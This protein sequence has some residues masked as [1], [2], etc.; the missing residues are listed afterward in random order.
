MPAIPVLAYHRIGTP[1]PGARHPDTYVRPRDFARQLAL[2]KALG[3]RTIGAAE[4]DEARR[5][6]GRA[7]A[8]KPLLLTFDDGSATL[9]SD[10]L[11]LLKAHGFRAVVF[12]VTSEMGRPAA[13]DGEG[14]GSGHRQLTPE[15]LRTLRAEGWDA[16]SHTVTHARL[17]AL[18]DAALRR[19][20]EASKAAL[21][22]AWGAAISWF[23]Y[24]YGD[25]DDAARAAVSRAGYRAAFA[26]ERG[27]GRALSI[28]RRI[29]SGRA[30]LLRFARHLYQAGRMAKR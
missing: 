8:G 17:T 7:P 29:I 24:P 10:A 5:E 12:M 6:G 16:G 4:Y 20:V 27:D 26:T 22:S 14:P 18:D 15:E 2:L 30:G 21:E 28:P 25:Y 3:Y 1:P 13:W 19:E 11:P 9:V 23:A